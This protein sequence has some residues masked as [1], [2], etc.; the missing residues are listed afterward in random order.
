M[1]TLGL[2]LH[3]AAARGSVMGLW[4]VMLTVLQRWGPDPREPGV[5]G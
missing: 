4:C 3:F 1:A 5:P 2:G